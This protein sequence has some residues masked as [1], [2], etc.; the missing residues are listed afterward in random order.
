MLKE[1]KLERTTKSK[2]EIQELIVLLTVALSTCL[3]DVGP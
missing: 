3:E 2:T 1:I